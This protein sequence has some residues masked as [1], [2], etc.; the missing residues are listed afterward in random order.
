MRED[1]VS[2]FLYGLLLVHNEGG[3]FATGTINLGGLIVAQVTNLSKVWTTYEGGPDNSGA[4]FFEPTGIP[5]GFSVLG[6]YAQPNNRALLGSVLVGKDATDGSNPALVRPTDYA[7]IWSSQSSRVKQDVP[8]YIWAPIPPNGY[9]A[10]GLIVTRRPD[11]P[12][13]DKVRCVRSDLT[14]A[15]EPDEWIWGQNKDVESNDFNIYKSRPNSGGNQASALSISTFLVQNSSGTPNSIPLLAC[16]ANANSSSSMPNLDQIHKIIQ[17]Y[18][19]TIYFHPDEDYLPSSVDWFFVNGALLYKK[20]DE[21]NPVSIN[22]TGSNLPQG[23]SNDDSYWLDLPRD[24]N[25]GDNLKKGDLG[26]ATAYI[27]IKPM[28]G[29]TYT[30]LAI[31]LFYPFNGASRAKVASFTVPLG[32]L[33]EHVGDWEHVTLRVSNFDGMLK[34]VY[35]AQHSGGQWVQASDLEFQEG[36]KVVA[37]SSL[38]GHASYPR[39]G[40]VLQ[41]GDFI[42]VRNDATKSDKFL[43]TAKSYTIIS[44]DYLGSNIVT[45]PPWLNY[46]RKWGPKVTYDIDNEI[47]DVAKNLPKILRS[48]FGKFVR[49]LPQ[50]LLGE[51]GPIGPKMKSN[52]DGDEE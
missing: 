8:G 41:G 29:G 31:W 5:E 48:A 35:F 10:V 16:L 39:S 22:S 37:Y 49:S 38:H 23:G 2:S 19:P 33:G 18:S 21:S 4:T 26:S 9:N 42:G 3:G 7:L 17:T 15:S 44:A 25:A 20:G 24:K 6:H 47:N 1:I 13:L 32:K 52:W 14:T 11:E 40:L 45:E 28:L 46:A 51:D 36:N 34:Q 12:S 30:D 43:D 50:E 27:H